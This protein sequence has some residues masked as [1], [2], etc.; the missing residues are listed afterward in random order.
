MVIL[1]DTLVFNETFKCVCQN[2]IKWGLL[3]ASTCC[4][5][6]R[7]VTFEP[8]PRNRHQIVVLFLEWLYYLASIVF[9]VVV[10]VV[11]VVVFIL[12]FLIL[13]FII[14]VK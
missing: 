12:S 10:V 6:H 2:K 14:I 3:V 8:N 9:V 7:V 1:I 4:L 11:V 13:K 5:F